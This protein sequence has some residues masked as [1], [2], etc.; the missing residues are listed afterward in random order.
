M[1][2]TIIRMLGRLLPSFAVLL[3][4]DVIAQDWPQWGHDATK[5]MV[6]TG[7]KGL[8]TELHAGEFI[9]ASDR[10]D[11]TTTK[12]V[13]WIAKLGSQS[14]GNPTVSGGRVFVGTNNDVPRDDRYQGDRSCVYCFDEKTGEFLWQL[15]NAK[16]GTGKVSDWEFLGICSSPTVDGDRVYFVTNRCEVVC[17]DVQGM[18]NGNDGPFQD[19]GLHAA[20]PDK[21]PFEVKAT[22]ADI[23]WTFSMIDE[24]GVFPH[25]IT[26]SSILVTGDHLWVSTSNGVSYD[27]TETPAPFAPSLILLDKKTGELLGEEGSGLSQRILHGNWSS[28]AY[29]KQG[30]L[31]L[32]IFG[33]PDGWV[34]AFSPETVPDPEDPEIKI[35]KEVW[36]LDAN[37]PEYREREGKK[38]RY[39]TRRGPSEV[40][41]TPVVYDGY[42]YAAI[43][44][45]PE[46][47]EGVGNLVCIDPTKTGDVTKT[48]LVW[49]YSKINR[50]ISTM[51]LLD[52]LLF[53]ADYSGF[54]Y[55][56]DAKTGQEIWIHDT[57]GHIWG[58]PLVADG[59]V[60][61]G[62][63]DGYLTILPANK[64][65]EKGNEIEIDMMSPVYS[66]PIAA[67]GTLYIATHTHLF[68]IAELGD[69]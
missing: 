19:E 23:I 9:G 49:N 27:H 36:R 4:G 65:F 14:Y 32:C 13:K 33:G 43:G 61:V 56:L 17:L 8:P 39:A 18:K 30:D 42:V 38:V 29:F 22:D 67:N 60:Y 3:C 31:E 45:D 53:T 24:V 62:N 54:V 41:A 63:E 34:Y 26:S 21:E 25:N 51:A 58:S 6:A 40:L 47:G 20:W 52:G 66:S 7:V 11:M 64:S 1:N 48:G 68:A 57:K 55:C 35:L 37:L 10:I 12:N 28:P 2:N 44:Q 59:K 46:H 16:L 5:N 15:N 50:S 69:R